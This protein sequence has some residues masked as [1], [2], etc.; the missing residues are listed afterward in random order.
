MELQNKENIVEKLLDTV[1]GC[2][3]SQQV[4]REERFFTLQN[5]YIKELPRNSDVMTS[6]KKKKRL[7]S[8]VK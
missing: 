4:L 8:L 3:H 5:Q 6:K 7:A 1:M 2:L